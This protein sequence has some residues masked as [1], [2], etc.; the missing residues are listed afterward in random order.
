MAVTGL[1]RC[2]RYQLSLCR[3]VRPAKA[4]E[5]SLRCAKVEPETV[6]T[7]HITAQLILSCCLLLAALLPCSSDPDASDMPSGSSTFEVGM[8]VNDSISSSSYQNHRYSI[9]GTPSPPAT[10]TFCSGLAPVV[11]ACHYSN[12]PL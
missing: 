11:V 9:L 8:R 5:W 2:S 6:G 12:R 10:V 4:R 3:C 1:L 7:L